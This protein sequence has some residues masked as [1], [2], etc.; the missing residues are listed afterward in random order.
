MTDPETTAAIK[1]LTRRVRDRDEALRDGG[2]Y[3]DP[4]VFAQEFLAALRGQGWRV[5]NTA[6][7]P[8]HEAGA[9][10]PK[11]KDAVAA[12]AEFRARVAAKAAARPQDGAA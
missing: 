7:P 6:P 1:A 8:A 3:A 11:G 2:E 12:V 10:L 5:T 4:E 9:G